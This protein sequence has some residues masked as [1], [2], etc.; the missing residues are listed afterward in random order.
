MIRLMEQN[1]GNSILIVQIK[2]MAVR[3][4]SYQK[5]IIPMFLSGISFNVLAGDLAYNEL[6]KLSELQLNYDNI[7]SVE[8][9]GAYN[10]TA[11]VVQQNR[12]GGLGNAAKIKQSGS[13]NDAYIAQKGSGNKAY[14]D[15]NGDDNYAAVLEDGF[16]N[17][18]VI[19]QY[20]SNNKAAIIQKGSKNRGEIT[21][22]GN[23]NKALIVQKSNV[24][25]FKSDINQDGGQT[26]VIINGMN[27]SITVR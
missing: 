5:L 14:I 13:R 23:D 26:H 12:Y 10:S 17:T 25:Y 22:Y 6:S 11:T 20:G 1:L 16:D 27:K 9:T 4:K 2:W 8:Q 24:R 7:S 18:G 3:M 15:Q 21:Q 19:L